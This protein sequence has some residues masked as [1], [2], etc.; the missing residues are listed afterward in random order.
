MGEAR[1]TAHHHIQT[2]DGWMTARQAADRGL[3]T[4][5]TNQVHPRVY[6]LCLVGGGNIIIDTT[7][8]L[9]NAPTQ[10]MAATMGYRFEPST[11]PPHKSSLTYTDSIRAEMGQIEGMETGHKFF[12]FN[13]VETRPNG[14]L[15][16]RN[17]PIKRVDSLIPDEER[18]GTT[19]RPLLH[20]TIT[21]QE[22]TLREC[23]AA[24]ARDTTLQASYLA[25]KT[26]AQLESDTEIEGEQGRTQYG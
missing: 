11:D 7:A 16:F 1:I 26:T 10:T 19:L 4:L 14:E 6:S 17:I 2:E 25:P 8:T 5:L 18:L 3:G 9:Q 23:R 21:P 22:A 15:H 24:I 13:E 20:D 12:R